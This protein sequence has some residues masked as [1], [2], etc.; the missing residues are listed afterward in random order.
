MREAQ[1]PLYRLSVIDQAGYV[2]DIYEPECVS[3]EDAFRR[4]E[5]LVGR[6]SIDIWQA[7]RWIAW[8]DGK[9][10]ARLALAHHALSAVR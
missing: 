1:M 9:D 3:D 7:D 10:P 8:L 6:A 4:A 5:A 2:I